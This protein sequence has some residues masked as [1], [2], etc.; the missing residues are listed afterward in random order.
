PALVNHT[1]AAAAAGTTTI[2]EL[3]DGQQHN[4]NASD[5]L[6]AQQLLTGQQQLSASLQW[7]LDASIP[8]VNQTLDLS[9]P[10]LTDRLSS[11]SSAFSSPIIDD[12]HLVPAAAAAAAAAIANQSTAAAADEA[13]PKLYWAIVFIL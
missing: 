13:Q 6:P 5:A 8:I 9:W 12:D 2:L 3:L 11:S 10:G 7:A 1:T 4:H